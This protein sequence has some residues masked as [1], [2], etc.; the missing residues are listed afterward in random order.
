MPLGVEKLEWLGYRQW[1]NVEDIF[2]HFERMYERDIHMDGQ[3]GRRTPH[4]DIGLAY[5]KKDSSAY[6]Q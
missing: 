4:D 1:K 2:I 3:T 6:S 5:K